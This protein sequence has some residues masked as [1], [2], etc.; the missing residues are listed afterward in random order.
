MD[1]NNKS[2]AI[3]AAITGIIYSGCSLV[4]MLNFFATGYSNYSNSIEHAVLKESIRDLEERMRKFEAYIDMIMD[5]LNSKLGETP[6]DNLQMPNGEVLF[7]IAQG[8]E[9][10]VEQP[11][12]QK[13]YATLFKNASSVDGAKYVHPAFAEIISQLSLDEIR[14]MESL[15]NSA[16]MAWPVVDVIDDSSMP[17]A[18]H[19]ILTNFTIIGLCSINHKNRIGVYI[20]NL[21]RLNLIYIPESSKLVD[22]SVYEPLMDPGSYKPFIPHTRYHK[23]THLSFNKR[24]FRLTNLG[25]HFKRACFDQ[26]IR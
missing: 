8:I 12:L 26:E 3:N 4:P 7:P 15:V 19:P 22:D 24:S 1:Q 25:L 20:D 23:H 2:K 18:Y 10:K 21:Q 14:I 9:N 16:T 6:E 13:V 17:Q 11:E 5:I